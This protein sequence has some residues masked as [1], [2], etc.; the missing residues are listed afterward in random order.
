M[1]LGVERIFLS[2]QIYII[3]MFLIDIVEQGHNY[4]EP[5]TLANTFT[6]L[7]KVK[8]KQYR[9][10]HFFVLYFQEIEF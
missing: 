3:V 7:Q 6:L 5:L 9:M 1:E 10:D 2:I 4:L 8:A